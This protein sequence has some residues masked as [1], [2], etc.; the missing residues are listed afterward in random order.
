MNTNFK[1]LGMGALG[2]AVGSQNA[3]GQEKKD[4]QRPNVLL[5]LADDMGYSDLGCFGSEINTPNLNNLA[6]EGIKFTQFYNTARCCPSRASLLTGL[7]PHEA[8]IGQ[9]VNNL[10]YP[11]YQGYL[12]DECVTIAEALKNNGYNTYM[13]GKWHVGGSGKLATQTR[14]R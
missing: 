9:M 1:L 10:G 5:I 11:S 4:I 2:I 14:V 6:N 3:H 12:N 7:Y 13:S 8:G